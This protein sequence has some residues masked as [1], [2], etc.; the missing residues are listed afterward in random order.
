MAV[1]MK[2]PTGG[3]NGAKECRG[4]E[5]KRQNEE[6]DADLIDCETVDIKNKDT[7]C[8]RNTCSPKNI[9]CYEGML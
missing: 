1:L 8:E 4:T 5:D 9:T 2:T 7:Q 3:A 6:G